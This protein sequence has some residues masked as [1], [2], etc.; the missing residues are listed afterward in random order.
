LIIYALPDVYLREQMAK[1][2][3]QAEK[4]RREVQK[5]LKKAEKAERKTKPDLPGPTDIPAAPKEK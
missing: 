5:K 4:R 1:P 3:Y 2:N